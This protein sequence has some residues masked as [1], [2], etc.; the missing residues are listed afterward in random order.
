M[1]GDLQRAIVVGL[2]SLDLLVG[3]RH[4]RALGD[5]IPADQ[6]ILRDDLFVMRTP[7]LAIDSRAAT[8][9]QHVEVDVLGFRRGVEADRDV[10]ESERD[11]CVAKRPESHS[12]SVGLVCIGHSTRSAVEVPCLV[13]V[14][15][16]IVSRPALLLQGRAGFG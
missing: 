2:E 11:R 9:V 15:A 12:T 13:P 14:D 16:I 1:I 6:L 7:P 4:V 10:D 5:R 3:E 8:L